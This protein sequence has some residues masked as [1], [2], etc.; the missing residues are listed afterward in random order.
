MRR[1]A[2]A[3]GPHGMP[4]ALIRRH[5]S[6]RSSCPT[7][8]GSTTVKLKLFLRKDDDPQKNTKKKKKKKKFQYQYISTSAQCENA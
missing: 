3:V 6:I 5:A 8:K 2:D 4:K 7:I 1:T